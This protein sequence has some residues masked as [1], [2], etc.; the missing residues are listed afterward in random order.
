MAD[1][2][3]APPPPQRG[4][5]AA[6]WNISGYKVGDGAGDTQLSRIH[7]VPVSLKFS[8]IASQS[9]AVRLRAPSSSPSRQA[10]PAPNAARPIAR[11]PRGARAPTRAKRPFT[12]GKNS[13]ATRPQHTQSL[14]L[15]SEIPGAAPRRPTR[16]SRGGVPGAAPGPAWSRV[17][18]WGRRGGAG[19][20]GPS[21]AGAASGSFVGG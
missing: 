20:P 15:F 13:T 1:S 12:A 14:G 9:P 2:E 4:E 10:G 5:V 16:G 17:A 6:R 3:C 21:E 7:S 19:E 11:S 8:P 18:E